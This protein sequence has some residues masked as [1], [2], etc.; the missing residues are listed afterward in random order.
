MG[1]HTLLLF[2]SAFGLFLFTKTS[3]FNEIK[4]FPKQLLFSRTFSPP[5]TGMQT[6]IKSNYHKKLFFIFLLSFH[7]PQNNMSIDL[8][9]KI[10]PDKMN[11][12][13]TI[14][15]NDIYVKI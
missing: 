12:K 5:H 3:F 2:T 6:L 1:T 13:K 4:T 7:P 8:A 10:H 11:V 9:L 14:E 15:K